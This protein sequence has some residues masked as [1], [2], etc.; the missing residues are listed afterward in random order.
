MCL[1]L[2]I[3]LKILANNV[4]KGDNCIRMDVRLVR[5]RAEI[6]AQFKYYV[7]WWKGYILTNDANTTL[8]VTW[9]NSDVMDPSILAITSDVI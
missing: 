7:H 2:Y 9:T 4:F 1:P 6:V 5:Y 8:N 3:L